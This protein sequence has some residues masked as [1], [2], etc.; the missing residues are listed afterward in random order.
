MAK[1]KSQKTEW[2]HRRA[3]Q[4]AAQRTGGGLP[5][6]IT[7][8]AMVT[9]QERAD[10][11]AARRRHLDQ[12]PDYDAGWERPTQDTVREVHALLGHHRREPRLESIHPDPLIAQQL[13]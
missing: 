1:K 10:Y 7:P 8:E 12:F 3:A 2:R 6:R 11:Q 4:I 9:V 5:V 13:L